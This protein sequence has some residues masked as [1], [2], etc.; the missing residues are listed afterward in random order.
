MT[1]RTSVWIPAG[2]LFA[3]ATLWINY[4][5][6]VNIEGD[7]SSGA[8]RELGQIKVGKPAP[9]FAT[10][11]LTSHAV[12]LSAY[13]GQKVVLIDFWATWCGPCKMAMPGL[14]SLLDDFKDRGLEILSVNE[15]ESPEQA[16]TFISRKAYGCH[17]LMDPKSEIG[18]N[19]GVRGIPTL[20]LVDKAGIVQW[21]RVGYSPDDSDL[22]RIIEKQ[23]GQ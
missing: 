4:E 16:G 18:A 21:I 9:E 17:V 6:K 3:A 5:V 8:T 22:R 23:L 19:Y 20:V 11:D 12:K 15:G 2:I 7:A 1:L 14:Q 10:S 13:R